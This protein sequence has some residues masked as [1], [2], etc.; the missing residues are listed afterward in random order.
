MK[1]HNSKISVSKTS[2]NT[3]KEIGIELRKTHFNL[4]NDSKKI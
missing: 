3:G 1:N 4:G 2:R